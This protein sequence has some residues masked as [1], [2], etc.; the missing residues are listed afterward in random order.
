MTFSIRRFFVLLF[1][2]AVG[3]WFVADLGVDEGWS[4]FVSFAFLASVF[5]VCFEL[6][7]GED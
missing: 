4:Y 6:D 2:A 3:W 1:L 5:F 7:P